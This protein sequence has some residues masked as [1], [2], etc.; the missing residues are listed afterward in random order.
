MTWN[1]AA[2]C[3]ISS[4][5]GNFG[6]DKITRAPFVELKEPPLLA[7]LW[8]FWS[9]QRCS[10]PSE[11]SNCG[12]WLSW[13]PHRKESLFAKKSFCR[14]HNGTKRNQ[15]HF[16]FL[17]NKTFLRLFSPKK[18]LHK[19]IEYK[20]K[21]TRDSL[22]Q[23]GVTERVRQNQSDLFR[24]YKRD[25]YGSSLQTHQLSSLL[26]WPCWQNYLDSQIFCF[27]LLVLIKPARFHKSFLQCLVSL[28]DHWKM[29][30]FPVDCPW[31][32]LQTAYI[33]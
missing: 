22:V 1:S 3:C 5:S 11:W 28:S 32:P 27:H 8:I 14:N 13:V 18:K 29:S 2:R 25:D 23:L 26:S 19:C 9:E 12:S 7:T 20:K 30:V 21:V 24:R 17:Y 10:S 4:L 33:E 31:S 16:W 15:Q 6:R